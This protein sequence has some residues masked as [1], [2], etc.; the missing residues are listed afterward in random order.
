M[1]LSRISQKRANAPENE[2][3][4][5]LDGSGTTATDVASSVTLSK[6]GWKAVTLLRQRGQLN[7]QIFAN[8]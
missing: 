1:R 8:D 3:T 4:L 2:Q 5:R 6:P 7:R